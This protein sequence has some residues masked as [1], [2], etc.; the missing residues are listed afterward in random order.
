MGLIGSIVGGIA[1]IAGGIIAGKKQN[2][3]YRQQ[4]EMYNQRLADIKAHRDKLYYQD[5]TQTAANQTA[6][7]QARELLGDQAK[8]AAASAAVAGGTDEAV[9]LQKAAATKA[10]GN[11]M[12]QQAVQGEARKDA[13]WNSADSQIDAFSQY[14]AQSKLQQ[15]QDNA[16]A[17][18][19]AA[20][21]LSSSLG[22]L[23]I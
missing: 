23:P 2:A 18:S 7:T 16:K 5:P 6:V 19:Q 1:G 10:I 11:M 14:L 4:Q 21:G 9:A 22:S 15:A 20:G 13:I 17:I 3:G 8:Q 12:Q